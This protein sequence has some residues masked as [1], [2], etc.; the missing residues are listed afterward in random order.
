M[1][2][3][4]GVGNPG[5]SY[6]KTRLNA[7]FIAVDKIAQQLANIFPRQERFEWRFTQKYMFMVIV[8][9]PLALIVKPR[10]NISEFPSAVR[11][12][13]KF[14][15][16][17]GEKVSGVSETGKPVVEDSRDN[18]KDDGLNLESLYIVT[19]DTSLA[20]KEYK[21][22]KESFGNEIVRGVAKSLGDNSFW[23]IRVGVGGIPDDITAQQ[24]LRS[25]LND[26]EYASLR[27]VADRIIDE[28]DLRIDD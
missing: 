7:G 11:R 27:Y 16:K 21:V 14:Y 2:L 8:P 10:T 22:D 12:L 20:I 18:L 26:I 6:A 3:I 1:K 17:S 5:K 19:Y 28:L 24:Y 9:D 15:L 4:I 23:K 25:E 13:A